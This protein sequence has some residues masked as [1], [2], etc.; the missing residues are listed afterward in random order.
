MSLSFGIKNNSLI[1]LDQEDI[2]KGF[3]ASYAYEVFR[4]IKA[5]PLFLKL[6]YQRLVKTCRSLDIKPPKWEVLDEDIQKLISLNQ[7]ENINIKIALDQNYYAVFPI[8]SNYPTNEQYLRGVECALLW[9]ER[10]QP[11]IKTFQQDLRRKS[12][13]QMSQRDIYESVLV[14]QEGHITE[15]S[16]SNLFF[17]Q[18]SKLITAP[19]DWVLPG[20]TRL[21]VLE[22]CRD[23]KFE[24]QISAIAL[25]DL[26][27]MDA[28]FICGTSPGI[29]PIAQI[30]DIHFDVDN[31]VLQKIHHSYHTKYLSYQ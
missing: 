23:L 26:P 17:I 10:K 8:I 21:K 11:E 3:H 14:N 5:R 31:P 7:I 2:L 22:L 30:E 27:Q 19:D 15:G 28:A 16:R 13:K 24:V 6:H 29:L 20:I 25:A 1:Q 9:E 4:L 18:D 12:N